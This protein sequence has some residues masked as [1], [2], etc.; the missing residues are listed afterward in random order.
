M[1]E[2]FVNQTSQNHPPVNPPFEQIEVRQV[3]KTGI[4]C[5][6]I[7]Q[8]ELQLRI[9]ASHIAMQVLALTKVYI[10][11]F[12]VSH[13]RGVARGTDGGGDRVGTER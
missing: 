3:I 12:A 9:I 2:R 6:I 13:R 11:V 5:L 10:V 1:L 8:V 4:G 7:T